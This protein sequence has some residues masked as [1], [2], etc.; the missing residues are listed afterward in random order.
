MVRPLVKRGP[1]GRRYLV[2]SAL[3]KPPRRYDPESDAQPEN[4]ATGRQQPTPPRVG[5]RGEPRKKLDDDDVR[6]IRREYATGKWSQADLAYIYGVGQA[7]IGNIVRGDSYKD[8]K[9][10]PTEQD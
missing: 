3:P 6:A 5:R 1:D 10:E 9:P 4:D 7:A 8:V 2:P